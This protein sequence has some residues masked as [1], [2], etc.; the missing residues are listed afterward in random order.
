MLF[1]IYP[2]V[3]Y[4]DSFQVDLVGRRRIDD[5]AR[6]I[7]SLA[8]VSKKALLTKVGYILPSKGFTSE[9]RL[10]QSARLPCLW[11]TTHVLSLEFWKDVV[12]VVHEF[13]EVL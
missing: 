10:A 3:T 6:C 13:D 11:V 8:S 5:G 9:I 2:S 1:G 12:E 4:S 7:V